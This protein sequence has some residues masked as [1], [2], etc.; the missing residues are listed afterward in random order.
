MLTEKSFDTGTVKLNYVEGPASGLPLVLLHGITL[1]WQSFLPVIPTLAFRYHVYGVD[2][3]GH[4]LSGH[5]TGAYQMSDYAEDVI[6]FIRQ[7]I[8]KPAILIGHSLGATVAIEIAAN[9]PDTVQALVLEDPALYIAPDGDFTDKVTHA[10]FVA[11]RDLLLTHHSIEEIMP[12]LAALFPD[13]DQVSLR[14]WSKCLS[15]LDHD[16]LTQLTDGHT[17]Q[18]HDPDVLLSKI[19]CPVLLL[20]GDPALGA[21]L[22]DQD[23]ERARLLLKHCLH[24]RM[25]GVG[26]MLHDEKTQAFCYSVMDFL[27]SL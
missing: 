9:A 5:M 13:L 6:H 2:L 27:E 8:G 3:R 24:I 25:A 22:Y 15:L 21:L 14:S 18:Q 19:S 4:G 20:Q 23:V 10:A 12:A 26:H 16:A 17:H 11:W 7:Q 1:R